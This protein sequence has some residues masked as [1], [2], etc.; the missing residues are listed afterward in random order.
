MADID[1]FDIDVDGGMLMLML[2]LMLMSMSM[3]ILIDTGANLGYMLM[4][5]MSSPVCT[6]CL[7]S[8]QTWIL[9]WIQCYPSWRY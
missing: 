3:L 6:T 7:V 2:M 4:F 8:S 9:G 5:D 1:I